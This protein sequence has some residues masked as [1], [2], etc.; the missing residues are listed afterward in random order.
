MS[1]SFFVWMVRK[2]PCRRWI[3][4][5]SSSLGLGNRSKHIF[6]GFIQLLTVSM[7]I[8]Q[9]LMN[10]ALDNQFAIPGDAGFPLNQAFEAPRDRQ[11]AETL[12][13]Y[14]SQVRQEL[15]IRLLARLYAGNSSTPS[16]VYDPPFLTRV[17][18][19]ESS[20]G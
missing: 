2:E 11:D 7:W 3:R 9:A 15:A 10:T 8:S 14:L 20:R 5:V 6:R 17:R 19:N 12:R 1:R 13:Q 4:G 16:K 18:P